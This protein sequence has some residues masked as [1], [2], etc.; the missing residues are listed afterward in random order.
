MLWRNMWMNYWL[1]K[2]EGIE[3]SRDAL[4]DYL[5][6]DPD[7]ESAIADVVAGEVAG[8]ADPTEGKIIT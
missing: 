3:T 8:H 5:A 4:Q 7:F 2:A 1:K 6:K